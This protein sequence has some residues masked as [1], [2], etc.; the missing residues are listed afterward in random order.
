MSNFANGMISYLE[1]LKHQEPELPVGISTYN[2][3]ADQN[4]RRCVSSFYRK[5]FNDEASRQVLFGINPFRWGAGLTGI[6]FTD[7]RRL[8]EKCGIDFKKPASQENAVGFIY[9]VVDQLG[10]PELFYQKFYFNWLCPLGL[11][12]EKVKDHKGYSYYEKASLYQSVKAL[13]ADNIAHLLDI[14]TDRE[15]CFVIGRGKNERYLRKI[16]GEHGFFRNI[17]SLEHPGYITRYHAAERD[18]Y[19]KQYVEQIRGAE[20][21]GPPDKV[22][23]SGNSYH[24]G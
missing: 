15:N 17:I 14:G 13:I 18:R 4:V 11:L 10:G 3:Y 5:F 6:P 19:L 24:T 7:A 12:E 20:I 22:V 2:P 23:G 16:N 21:I 1:N 9:E 8:K